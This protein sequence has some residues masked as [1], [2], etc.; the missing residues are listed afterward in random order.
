[1]VL[2]SKLKGNKHAVIKEMRFKK[3]DI[4]RA[5]SNA[6]A[7]ERPVPTSKTQQPSVSFFQFEV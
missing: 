7:N 4:V 5:I 6:N 2:L 1:M 3:Q